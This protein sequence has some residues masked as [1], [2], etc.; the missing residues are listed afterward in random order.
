MTAPTWQI[1]LPFRCGHIR[2]ALRS[3]T[4]MTS[5]ITTHRRAAACAALATSAALAILAACAPLPPGAPW[6]AAATQSGLPDA[7]YRLA[8]E[9]GHRVLRIDAQRSRSEE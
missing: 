1:V 8:R 2:A 9:R 5:P 4:P 7:D 3:R 6:P